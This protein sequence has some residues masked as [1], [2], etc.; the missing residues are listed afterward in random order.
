MALTAGALTPTANAVGLTWTQDTLTISVTAAAPSLFCYPVE[1]RRGIPVATAIPTIQG[2]TI[3][4]QFTGGA[5]AVGV[6]TGIPT[7]LGQDLGLEENHF[8]SNARVS[9]AGQS[10]GLSRGTPVI[11]A[12]PTLA[13]SNI[14]LTLSVGGVLPVGAAAPTFAPQ[15]IVLSKTWDIAV[16][17]T[18]FDIDGSDVG[19]NYTIVDGV[20][21]DPALFSIVGASNLNF[22]LGLG[23]PIA[24][25]AVSIAAYAIGLKYDW[26]LSVDRERID[27]NG[28]E[29]DLSFSYT[30]GYSVG[31]AELS[32]I[33]NDITL[34]LGDGR[35]RRVKYSFSS[36]HIEISLSNAEAVGDTESERIISG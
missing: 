29:I 15:D 32:I 18:A 31:A 9:L 26:F 21:V 20:R 13:A 7:L 22:S 27:L 34:F 23:I 17:S 3:A 4:F 6:D 1:G 25:T 8:F 33:G 24:S 11:T 19:F 5:Q 16:A 14:T 28:Q 35:P 12:T 30:L 36:D 10:V 2:S